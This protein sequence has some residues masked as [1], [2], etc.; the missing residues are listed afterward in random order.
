MKAAATEPALSVFLAP[1]RTANEELDHRH[2]DEKT[3]MREMDDE[4]VTLGN[5]V[6]MLLSSLPPRHH[7]LVQARMQNP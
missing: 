4:C 6:R 2:K 1:P 7:G 5:I 3:T